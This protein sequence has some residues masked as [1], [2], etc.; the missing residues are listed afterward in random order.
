[1]NT[2]ASLVHPAAALSWHINEV[3]GGGGTAINQAEGRGTR[4]ENG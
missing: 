1:M 2:L 3:E 4:E